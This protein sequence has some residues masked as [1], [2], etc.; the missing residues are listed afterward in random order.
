MGIDFLILSHQLGLNQFMARSTLSCY[1]IFPLE[2]QRCFTYLIF[3]LSLSISR[4][5]IHA[6]TIIS[7]C[8][9]NN[10]IVSCI[11]THAQTTLP[12][13]QKHILRTHKISFTSLKCTKRKKPSKEK[14]MKT[15]RTFYTHFIFDYDKPERRRKRDGV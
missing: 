14:T 12:F 9:G 11:I 4:Y 10:H 2:S 8:T 1:Q 5:L 6:T 3:S 7:C 13:E 15:I